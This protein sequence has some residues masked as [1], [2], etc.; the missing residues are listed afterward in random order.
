MQHDISAVKGDLSL[1]SALLLVPS[2]EGAVSL[3]EGISDKVI[4]DKV[5]VIEGIRPYAL[6]H[7]PCTRGTYF[8][9]AKLS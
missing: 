8:S 5:I 3:E 6:Y 7:R 9:G 2:L 1:T 4:V